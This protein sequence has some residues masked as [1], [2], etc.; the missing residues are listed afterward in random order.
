MAVGKDTMPIISDSPKL[1]KNHVGYPILP[2]ADYEGFWLLF[3]V[4]LATVTAKYQVDRVD[5]PTWCY[6]NCATWNVVIATMFWI[7]IQNVFMCL[8]RVTV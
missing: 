6:S 1:G 7:P 2:T 8:V 5:V 4:E 3:L